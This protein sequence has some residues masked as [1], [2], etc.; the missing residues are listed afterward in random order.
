MLQVREKTRIAQ[1]GLDL[2]LTPL[3]LSTH[4][5]CWGSVGFGCWTS[6]EVNERGQM[7]RRR[8]SQGTTNTTVAGLELLSYPGDINFVA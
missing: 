7:Q 1:A 3:P 6:Q 2:I 8:I 4:S 5:G